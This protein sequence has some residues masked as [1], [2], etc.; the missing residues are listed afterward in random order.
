MFGSAPERWGLPD[1]MTPGMYAHAASS[2]SCKSLSLNALFSAQTLS[3]NAVISLSFLLLSA[4]TALAFLASWRLR[5][6]R[7]SIATTRPTTTEMKTRCLQLQRESQRG[8]TAVA[9]TVCVSRDLQISRQFSA[10][11]LDAEKSF[12]C[13]SRDLQIS[14]QFQLGNWMR[15]NPSIKA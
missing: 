8:A 1:D 15:K 3:E 5:R 7:H 12:N 2:C 13:V 10:R 14:R 11:K 6:T 9:Q 4:A